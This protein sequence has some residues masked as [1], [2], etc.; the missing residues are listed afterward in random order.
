MKEHFFNSSVYFSF[1]ALTTSCNFA[2]SLSPSHHSHLL[3]PWFPGSRPAFCLSRGAILCKQQP[4][5]GKIGKFMRFIRPDRYSPSDKQDK[6]G[7][8]P[9]A[10][11]HIWFFFLTFWLI[12]CIAIQFFFFFMTPRSMN[13]FTKSFAVQSKSKTSFIEAFWTRMFAFFS[14][15][16][17]LPWFASLAAQ[18]K[19]LIP[20]MQQDYVLH[21][22]WS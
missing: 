11:F 20:Y 22:L 10:G 14:C 15:S 12:R 19:T 21:Y 16:A 13:W 18:H 1:S 3:F 6:N 4:G 5:W 17:R 9:S 2:L 7:S 8:L